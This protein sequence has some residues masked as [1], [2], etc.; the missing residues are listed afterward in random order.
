QVLDADLRVEPEVRLNLGTAAQVEQHRAGDVA[1]GKAELRSLRPV[2]G[3]CESRQIR[4]LL[5][6]NVHGAAH[7]ADLV[8]NRGGDQLVAGQ[9]TA[10]HLHVERCRQA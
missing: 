10:E 4:R 6:P 7:V 8:G 5:D 2:D 3:K 1:F 9:V